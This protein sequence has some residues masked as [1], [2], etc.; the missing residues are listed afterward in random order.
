MTMIELVKIN[1]MIGESRTSITLN[2]YIVELANALDGSPSIQDMIDDADD[3]Y[4][5]KPRGNKSQ[6]VTA[7]IAAVAIKQLQED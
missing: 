6:W 2:P 3:Y 1:V 4:N 5:M 7:V